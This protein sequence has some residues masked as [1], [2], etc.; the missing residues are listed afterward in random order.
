MNV[1]CCDF[2]CIGLFFPLCPANLNTILFSP[3]VLGN[4]EIHTEVQVEKF[5]ALFSED[6][7]KAYKLCPSQDL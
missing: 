4:K 6:H 7:W 1:V 3:S 5:L 2:V